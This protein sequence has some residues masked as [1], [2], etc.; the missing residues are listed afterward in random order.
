MTWIKFT[1][2]NKRREERLTVTRSGA[3]GFPSQFYLDNNVKDYKY[4]V[5]Y[6]D[7]DQMQVA[8]QFSNDDN[9]KDKISIIHSKTGNG[10]YIQARNFFKS[11]KLDPG[12]YV[13]RYEYSK[14]TDPGI[15]Q[16]LVI[17][18]KEKSQDEQKE[19]SDPIS[20]AVEAES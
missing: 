4:T 12:V 17:K 10:G 14:E 1:N 3:L 11:C 2:V 7:Q 13:G 15:G 16:L 6:F 9:E 18:L 5:L 19:N 8:L 20:V